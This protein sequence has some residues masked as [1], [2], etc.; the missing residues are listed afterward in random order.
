MIVGGSREVEIMTKN[1]LVSMA[2]F[3]ALVSGCTFNP[4]YADSD[5]YKCRPDGTC[6][7]GCS[8][9]GGDICVPDNQ[10]QGP[11]LC[12][13]CEEIGKTA[14]DGKCVDTEKD[15]ENCG[16]C[17]KACTVIDGQ[18]KCASGKCGIASCN[19]PFA[20][21]D[22][23]ID[24]GCE[25]N[26]D[27]DKD[28]CSGCARPCFFAHAG[29]AC[30]GGRCSMTACEPGFADCNLSEDDGCET[31][32]GTLANCTACGDACNNY[33]QP[34]CN[35]DGT[36]IVFNGTVRCDGDCI[37]ET[38]TDDC[39]M[40]GCLNGHCLKDI[41]PNSDMCAPGEWC[42]AENICLCGRPGEACDDTCCDGVCTNL[43]ADPQNC[44]ACG[45]TCKL[46]EHCYTG[47]CVCDDGFDNCDGDPGCETQLFDN[48]ENCG[49]CD[50]TCPDNSTCQDLDCVCQNDY[51]PCYDTGQIDQMSCVDLNSDNANCGSCGNSC[52][53]D[54]TCDGGG[55][56]IPG[57]LCNGTCEDAGATCC[58]FGQGF[59]CTTDICPGMTYNYCN[60]PGDCNSDETCCLQSVNA[61]TYLGKCQMSCTI[62]HVICTSDSQCIEIDPTYHCCQETVD[63][64]G[65]VY[66]F[67]HCCAD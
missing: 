39:G 23:K 21:C 15:I 61:S 37:Y 29:S 6:P 20:N 25:T 24:N 60:D 11:E 30:E 66:T 53:D 27:S 58:D 51:Q 46:N 31:K 40:L 19:P 22:G 12:A 14:C 52:T 10:G 7:D 49:A 42:N 45:L 2:A 34:K 28:N 44:G 62:A 3:L 48:S 43:N 47:S 59:I 9:L 67:N 32:L 57:F 8:C 35:I 4:R 36:L 41:C 16:E 54:A 64:A 33:P 1:K 5:Y 63:N 18:A 38:R 56:S 17:G 55:C 26:T 50:N 65:N 13:W